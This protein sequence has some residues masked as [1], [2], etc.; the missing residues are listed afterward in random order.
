MKKY[1]IFLYAFVLVWMMA[2]VYRMSAD[3]YAEMSGVTMESDA[4]LVDDRDADSDQ[5]V[6]AVSK[7]K[8]KAPAKAPAKTQLKG[9]VTKYGDGKKDK[10]FVGKAVK[11]FICPF[12]SW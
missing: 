7:A 12:C 10:T 8:A 5:Q 9:G 3:Q 4:Q 2:F 1:K 11:S 6:A